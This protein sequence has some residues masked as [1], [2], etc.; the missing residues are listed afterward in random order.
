MHSMS[1]K[2]LIALRC[3]R[4]RRYKVYTIIMVV[5]A[6]IAGYTYGK[7]AGESKGFDDGYEMARGVYMR[8]FSER[9]EKLNKLP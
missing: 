2:L 6:A 4:E 5:T 3:L 9:L 7:A 1:Q 8:A